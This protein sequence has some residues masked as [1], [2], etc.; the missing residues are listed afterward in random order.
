MFMTWS[1][2]C[3]GRCVSHIT[4][5]LS[6]QPLHRVTPVSTLYVYTNCNKCTFDRIVKVAREIIN[7]YVTATNVV[8]K[9][10]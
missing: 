9:H 5:T 8:S 3:V 2:V 7:R 10:H 4:I 6:P 1:S